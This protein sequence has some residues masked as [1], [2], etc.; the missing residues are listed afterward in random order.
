MASQATRYLRNLF[1]KMRTAATHVLVLMLSD[2]RRQRKPYALPV[3]YIP[4]RSL[5][6]QFVRD[7]TKD[8]KQHMT[9]RGMIIIGTTTDV[10][11][12]GTPIVELPNSDIPASLILEMHRLQA[13]GLSLEDAI[14]NIR[15][16]L[17]PPGY[18]PYPFRT[19]TEESLLDKKWVQEFKEQG[20]D[21]STHL[22]V[23]EVDPVTG[24]V[25]HER[26]D[27]NHLLKRMAGHLKEGGYNALQYEAF[28]DVLADPLSGLTHAAL[29]GKRKQS[30]KDA[31][32]LLSY[33]VV[34]LP[35]E[36]MGTIQRQTMSMSLHSG[37]RHQMGES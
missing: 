34:V 18:T 12:D 30:V 14:T 16:S 25:H 15:G 19:N 13:C 36:A 1:K 27:H 24:H 8:V 5:R 2:E 33:H 17:V 3:R 37:M 29:V 10:A 9:E 11:P 28:A 22:Y 26:A 4:Y 23:P 20:V 32:R 21:F 6:D 31:E 7:F 35:S